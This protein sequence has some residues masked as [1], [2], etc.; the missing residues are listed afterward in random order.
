MLQK[1]DPLLWQKSIWRVGLLVTVLVMAACSSQTPYQQTGFIEIPVQASAT[2]SPDNPTQSPTPPVLPL[3]M[4]GSYAVGKRRID[5]VDPDRENRKVSITLWY[6]SVRPDGAE[7]SVLLSGADHEPDRSG[8]PYPLLISSTEMAQ[9]MAAYLVSRGFV[10]AS[11]NGIHS[12]AHMREELYSQP[13]D[14][15]FA[16]DQAASGTLT[17]LDGMVDGDNVGAIGYSF[18]GYNTLAMS[19]ARVDPAYYLEQCADYEHSS[20]LYGNELSAFDCEPA[21]DWAAF[22]SLIPSRITSSTD[23]LWQPMTDERIR[24]VMPM[25]CEGLWLFGERGLA[26]M[27]K[28]TM[29]LAGTEDD[30]YPQNLL[31]FQEAG[32]VDKTFISFV[33]QSHMMIFTEKKV[34]RMAHFAAAFFGVHLQGKQEYAEYYSEAFVSQFDDLAWEGTQP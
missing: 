14:I 31:I 4:P 9:T 33:G 8:A 34:A 2:P 16:L 7:E 13:L 18:D 10:W 12:Y 19:G 25:A 15:L 22:S 26:E 23:V 29:F 30:L 6:P 1:I 5:L 21:Q 20:E 24:A 3:S 17:G 32:A 27:D 28:P 11:V